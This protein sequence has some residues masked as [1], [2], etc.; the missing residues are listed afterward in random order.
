MDAAAKVVADA[1]PD[2]TSATSYLL[3]DGTQ[4]G[5]Q[6]LVEAFFDREKR[7][8]THNRTQISAGIIIS[9]TIQECVIESIFSTPI[10][11]RKDLLKNIYVFGGCSMIT[12]FD[13]RL[14]YEAKKLLSA[15]AAATFN[16]IALPERKYSEWIGLSVLASMS[17]FQAQW[18]TKAQFDEYGIEIVR[19]WYWSEKPPAADYRSHF[20]EEVGLATQNVKTRLNRGKIALYGDSNAGKSALI[21][22]LKGEKFENTKPTMGIEEHLMEVNFADLGSG[23]WREFKKPEKLLEAAMAQI[24]HNAKLK[25]PSFST[26]VERYDYSHLPADFQMPS[27]PAEAF[28]ISIEKFYELLHITNK[29]GQEYSEWKLSTENNNKMKKLKFLAGYGDNGYRRDVNTALAAEPHENSRPIRNIKSGEI[30]CVLTKTTNNYYELAD[31]T[32]Y[33]PSI[34]EGAKWCGYTKR[35]NHPIYYNRVN[36]VVNDQTF[37]QTSYAST[38]TSTLE[39]SSVSCENRIS[40]SME[41][42]TSYCDEK[43]YDENYVATYLSDRSYVSP[44]LSISILEFG[45]AQ[46]FNVI[47]HL[48]ISSYSI[49]VIVFSMARFLSNKEACL[50]NL[51]EC[52]NSIVSHAYD[53][54]TM[55]HAKPRIVFVGTYKDKVSDF[56]AHEIISNSLCEEFSKKEGWE[57]VLKYERKAKS[58]GNVKFNYFPIDN[59]LSY[60]DPDLKHLIQLFETYLANSEVVNDEKPLSWLKCIDALNSEKVSSLS[61]RQVCKI[62][63]RCN[64]NYSETLQFLRYMNKVRFS[65]LFQFSNLFYHQQFR[66]T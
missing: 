15:K 47:H 7:S 63:N 31:G 8:I 23:S 52:F 40:D 38:V 17:S 6:N 33:V 54:G 50:Q 60:T 42:N 2:S 24:F 39:D 3:P 35:W 59:T 34:V 55:A 9:N 25:E 48:F 1:S 12:R 64:M 56:E 20:D 26:A 44:K 36:A 37:R 43:Y 57:L 45:G 22:S 14:S 29:I 4:I 19:K 28:D 27:F 66:S 51:N 62:T 53:N 16:V 5:K 41:I 11:I 46:A 18:I 21:R 61:L 32:G 13:Q 10:D 30:I 58:S 49:S 65:Q